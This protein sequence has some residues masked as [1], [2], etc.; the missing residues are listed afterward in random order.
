MLPA[1]RRKRKRL[2]PTWSLIPNEK[3]PFVELK[4]RL[5]AWMKKPSE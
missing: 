1:V 2:Q 5:Y 4:K 3:R